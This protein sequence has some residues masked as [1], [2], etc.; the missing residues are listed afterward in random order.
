MDAAMVVAT[1]PVTDLERA[2]RFYGETLGLTIL[3]ESPASIRLRAGAVS[4]LSIFKRPAVQAEHTLAHF[5]V[6]DI[7]AGRRGGVHRL[8]RGAARDHEPHRSDR[9]C[10]WRLVPRS[11]RQHVG[12]PPGRR[13]RRALR[14][15]RWC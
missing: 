12:P 11:R 5:E 15:R 10:P 3:W 14:K 7:E 4:E 9:P 8:R 1:I 13:V 6:P 2:K